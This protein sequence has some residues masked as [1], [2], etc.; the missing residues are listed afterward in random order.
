MWEL[1]DEKKHSDMKAIIEV[2]LAPVYPNV[3]RNR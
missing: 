2:M 3:S 1:E